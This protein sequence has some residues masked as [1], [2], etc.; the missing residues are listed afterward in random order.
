MKYLLPLLLIALT[1]ACAVVP[2]EGYGSKAGGGTAVI[3][4]KGKKTMEL[5]E[6]AVSAHLNHG[7]R[8]GGC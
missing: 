4:H 7:D 2:F 5:P 1:S 6:E 8:R 3:C